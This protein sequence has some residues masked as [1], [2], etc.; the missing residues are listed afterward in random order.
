MGPRG[1]GWAREAEG[2][3]R[4]PGWAPQA[5]RARPAFG[6]GWAREP[7]ASAAGETRCSGSVSPRAWRW[8]SFNACCLMSLGHNLRDAMLDA[9]KC[10]LN[11]E[12]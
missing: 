8:F 3:L 10:H 4:G 1:P 5:A 11:I 2:G 6:G 7:R 12:I 9:N